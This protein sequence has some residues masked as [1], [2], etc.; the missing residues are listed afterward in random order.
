MFGEGRDRKEKIR[1]RKR[2]GIRRV[3]NRM[4]G[5]TAD[6]SGERQKKI[7]IIKKN[8]NNNDKAGSGFAGEREEK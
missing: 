6:E 5:R 8:Y 3:G 2:A 7:I 4:E 1:R